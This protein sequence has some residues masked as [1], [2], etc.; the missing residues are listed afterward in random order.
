MSIS[1]FG[2]SITEQHAGYVLYFAK[3]YQNKV[4]QKGY[5][6]MHLEDAGICYIDDVISDNPEYCFIDWFSTG[7]VEMNN[8]TYDYLNTIVYKFSEK[9]IKL[10]FLFLRETELDNNRKLFYDYC[11]EYLKKNNLRYIDINKCIKFSKEMVRDNIHTTDYGSEIYASTIYN[12]F[13]KIKDDIIIPKNIP[14]N[15]YCDIKRININK[16]FTKEF[17]IKGDCKIIGFSLI[18]GPHSGIVITQKSDLNFNTWDPWCHYERKHICIK[19][20]D[21]TNEETFIVS[22]DKFDRSQCRRQY[23][24]SNILNVLKVVEIFYIGEIS[25]VYGN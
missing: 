5:G 22:Q 10:V 1:F 11:K 8:L 24:F 13:I 9:N 20:I 16:T 12:E 17:I 7:Y 25:N 3:K 19:H 18:I 15:I 6:G 2:A 23:D 21:I 4:Y 14:R